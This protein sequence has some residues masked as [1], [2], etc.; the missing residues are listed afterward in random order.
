MNP[1]SLLSAYV[2][3]RQCHICGATLSDAEQYI[4]LPCRSKLP[5]THYHRQLDNPMEQRFMGLFP[6]ERAT[7]HFFYSRGSDLAI[8]VADFKYHTFRGLARYMGRLIGEELFTTGFLSE[9]DVIVPV[10]MHF[11]K[12]ARRGY[13]QAVEIALGLANVTDIPLAP[14]LKAVRQHATQTSKT[15]EMRRKNVERIFRLKNPGELKEKNIL[16][17]DDVCTTGSTLSEAARTILDELPDARLWL[18]TLGVTF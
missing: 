12:R 18:L 3:P 7:G 8:L 2:F 10:P 5:R 11:V 14:N 16:L 4:C 13:N 1:F 17:L 6:F 9:I 15:L